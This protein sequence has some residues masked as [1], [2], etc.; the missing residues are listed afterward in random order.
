M[1]FHLRGAGR[2]APAWHKARPEAGAWL[3]L[4]HQHPLDQFCHIWA[5]E[6][7]QPL[8]WRG[9]LWPGG[10]GCLWRG[11]CVPRGWSLPL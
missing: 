6:E 7:G 3:R 5:A 10:G 4:G 11:H 9:C 1:T 8:A 2:N